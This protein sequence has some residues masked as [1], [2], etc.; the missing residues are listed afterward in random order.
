MMMQTF[1][2]GQRKQTEQNPRAENKTEGNVNI[3]F[4][5]KYTPHCQSVKNDDT[6]LDETRH[7]K[8]D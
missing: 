5:L 8:A 1:T 3:L 2:S 6:K 4:F 7:G